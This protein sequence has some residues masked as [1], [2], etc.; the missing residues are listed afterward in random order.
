MK[1]VKEA[2]VVE[3][4]YPHEALQKI[5]DQRCDFFS[6]YKKHN[7]LKIVV[8][9]ACIV[10]IVVACIVLPNA[11]KIDNANLKTGLTLGITV[12]ALAGMIAYSIISKR[13][14]DSKMKN[15]FKSFYENVNSYAFDQKGFD[16]VALQEPGKISLEQFNDCKLYKNVVTVGSRGLTEFEYKGIPMAV[17]D[18]AGN[19]QQDK[20][21]KPA[22]V[23]KYLLAASSY[24]E[25]E[26]II[27][28]VKGN[29][30]SLPPTVL[31]DY[32]L[33]SENEKYSIYSNNEK[34]DKFLTPTLV[35]K[36]EA[37][38]TNELLVDVAISIY[39]GRSFIMLGYDDPIMV[40]PLQNVFD[41]KPQEQYKKEL[42]QF[43][44]L[45]EALN[46]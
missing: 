5:E 38:K 3:S 22:F 13:I 2:E 37:I 20:R 34:W 36:I 19:V 18:C 24:E 30:R 46:K 8:A 35:K 40:L 44:G 14:I 27:V 16:K 32:K 42:V 15:Y 12:L 23:G 17:V 41:S 6:T 45:A 4:T 28:Y 11:V 26:P 43:C 29:D 39:G 25:T 33:V 7:T 1:K 9:L 21:M 31:E 10:L